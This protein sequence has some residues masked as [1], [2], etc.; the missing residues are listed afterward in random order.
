[1]GDWF[2]AH[3][4]PGPRSGQ[5]ADVLDCGAR[6]VELLCRYPELEQWVHLYHP[7]TQ[8]PIDNAELAWG[9]QMFLAFY[10][11]PELMHVFLDL[12]VEHYLS[13]LG[14][15]HRPRSE[16]EGARTGGS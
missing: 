8:G 5:G 13:F 3:G 4:V 9:S 10:D 6:F 15:W 12:M 14:G 1:M 16:G 11:D 7:D 2:S